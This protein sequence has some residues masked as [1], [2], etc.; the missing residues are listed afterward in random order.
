MTLPSLG[1]LVPLPATEH[2]AL[3][4]PPVAAA[5]AG[6][7]HAAEVAVV[8]I[9]PD[10]ADTAA[11]TEAYDLPLTASANCVLVGGRRDGEE[12]VAACIVRAD[13]RA[14]VNNRVKRLLDVRK[15]SFLPTDRA[16]EESGMEYGGITPVGLP[17]GWRLL[18]DARVADVDVAI[19]GSG[20]RR[21]KL[22]LPGR[23]VAAL[24]GAELVEDLAVEVG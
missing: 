18:V 15:A 10:L 22:L 5:L 19:I 6:W 7:A 8:E 23:L 4:A 17:A 20:V 21:S 2:P 24:P 9:D 14:D 12:R 3:L 1:S 11:M 16:V 13:T